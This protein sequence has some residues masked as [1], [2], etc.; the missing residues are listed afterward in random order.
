[1]KRPITRYIWNRVRF[2]IFLK[3]I[4]IN[5]CTK[6]NSSRLQNLR[7]TRCLTMKILN[8]LYQVISLKNK[9]PKRTN[10][11]ISFLYTIILLNN[12]YIFVYCNCFSIFLTVT[13]SSVS[14]IDRMTIL[15]MYTAE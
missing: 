14:Y 7:L 15:T 10:Y 9:I 11:R 3:F 8:F 2:L 6:Y 4:V 12:N 5:N 1:M 13:F